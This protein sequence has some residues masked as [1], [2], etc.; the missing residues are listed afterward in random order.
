MRQ[1]LL[2]LLV[3][4]L[5]PVAVCAQEPPA[6]AREA[7]AHVFERPEGQRLNRAEIGRRFIAFFFK[8]GEDELGPLSYASALRDYYDGDIKGA[9]KG[10]DAFFAKW[11]TI[12]NEEHRRMAGR[13]YLN[14]LQEAMKA[15]EPD[16]ER[17]AEIARMA[18]RHYRPTE[19]VARVVRTGLIRNKIPKPRPV[20]DAVTAEYANNDEAK[21]ARRK[22]FLALSAEVKPKAKFKH[23]REL[24]PFVAKSM[25]GKVID[26][27]KYRGK[28]LVVDFWATWCGPC[29]REMPNVVAAYEKYRAH[30]VEM[31]G[32]SLDRP[33]KAQA[34]RDVEKRFGMKW[35]QIYDGGYFDARLAVENSVSAVPCTY[36]IDRRGKTRFYRVNGEEL[37]KAIA[38]L[39]A[40]R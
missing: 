13:V 21:E 37:H 3:F 28:I 22:T 34:I 38:S 27:S 1:R 4:T 25:D 33:N 39:V 9:V 24:V 11:K 12:E 2:L 40:E 10:F 30:G 26:T 29:I 20:Y 7:L 15:K 16:V 32:V 14:G 8:Y 23:F 31:I 5:I 19:T 18:T 36:V 17:I 6:G 35:P